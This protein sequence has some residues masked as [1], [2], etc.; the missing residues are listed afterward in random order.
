MLLLGTVSLID[1][2]VAGVPLAVALNACVLSADLDYPYDLAKNT[3]Q[4]ILEVDEVLDLRI[5][6]VQSTRI[7]GD[8]DVDDN[9]MPRSCGDGD[10][11][12]NSD[13]HVQDLSR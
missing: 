2:N 1:E 4:V 8:V 13:A 11:F 6:P 3:S 5:V 9:G 7:A 10:V 12:A